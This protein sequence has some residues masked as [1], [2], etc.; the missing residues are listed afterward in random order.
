MDVIQVSG[1]RKSAVARVT[2]VKRGTGKVFVNGKSPEE[3]F[4]RKDLVIW[5]LKPL[6]ISEL[7]DVVD[8]KVRL[9]GGG[10]SG[11]AGAMRYALAKALLKLDESLKE[12]FKKKGMLTRDARK[13]ERMKYG[14]T[15]RRRS[16]Q[17]TKR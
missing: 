17:Y 10:L 14:K 7:K 13:K 6:E 3:Y 15:K 16:W 12:K 1:G 8:V 4:K 2:L 5:A 9:D 11:Q